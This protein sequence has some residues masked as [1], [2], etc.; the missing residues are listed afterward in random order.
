MQY[1]EKITLCEVGPRDGLQNEAKLLTAEEKT[2]L[3]EQM[4][5]AG[6][7]VIEV[8]SFVS[9]KAVPQMANTDD[10]F[11]T[12]GQREGVQLRALIANERG[13]DRAVACGCSKV[14]LN[15]SA[16]KAHNLANLNRTPQESVAGFK[17]CVEKAEANGIEVSG[18]ISMAFGSPWDRKIPVEDVKDIVRAYLAVGVTEISLSDASGMAY[19]SKV[20]EM[21]TQMKREFPKVTWWLHFHNTRGLGVANILAGM[22]AGVT[23]FD[24]SFAGVGG[25][26]FVPGAAGNVSTEDVVHMCD[27]MNIETGIDLDRAMGISRRVVELVGHPTDSY[28]LRAGKS[29]DLILELPK[30]QLRNQVKAK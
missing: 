17:A 19:P 21:C 27:E 10:V 25:C 29:K 18:S 12:L 3:I 20:Y 7:K 13:V 1:A 30:G 15:V 23:R 24:T 8:G 22:R 4:I 28:L 26:P 11:L 2:E 6:F 16:S 14:K 5:G 9:P